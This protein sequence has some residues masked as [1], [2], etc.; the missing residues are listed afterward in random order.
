MSNTVGSVSQ[1]GGRCL[2]VNV[3]IMRDLWPRH[4]IKSCKRYREDDDHSPTRKKKED[5]STHP[6]GWRKSEKGAMFSERGKARFDI[7]VF[8]LFLIPMAR[9]GT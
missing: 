6:A 3:S 5:D 9:F 4:N 7:V 2:R 8:L 1:L